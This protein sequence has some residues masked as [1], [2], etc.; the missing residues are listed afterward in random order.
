MSNNGGVKGT[1]VGH[2]NCSIASCFTI[3]L[4]G[5]GSGHM[6]HLALVST[7]F[8]FVS[9]V[10]NNTGE[11]EGERERERLC[12]HHVTSCPKQLHHML[13]QLQNPLLFFGEELVPA[14]MKGRGKQ[15]L[16]IKTTTIYPTGRESTNTSSTQGTLKLHTST[17][18]GCSQSCSLS[19]PGTTGRDREDKEERVKARSGSNQGMSR[20]FIQPQTK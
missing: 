7:E 13:M 17:P 18:T 14:P 10:L 9:S 6:W 3:A 15:S 5:G 8:C 19:L 2:I 20:V 12:V 1:H 11:G 16:A 4:L